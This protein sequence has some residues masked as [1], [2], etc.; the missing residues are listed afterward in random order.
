MLSW[1]TFFY[2]DTFGD[3]FLDFAFF[4]VIWGDLECLKMLQ[5]APY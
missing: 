1:S 3:T 4:L 5:N 2:G